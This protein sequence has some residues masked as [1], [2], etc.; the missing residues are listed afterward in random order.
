[1]LMWILYVPKPCPFK[2]K[3][4]I[5]CYVIEILNKNLK[6]GTELS[7]GRNI[8]VYLVMIIVY[9]IHYNITIDTFIL[10]G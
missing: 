6:D 7:F 10:D 5:V 1:M 8:L 9:Y 3:N 2:Q 4:L